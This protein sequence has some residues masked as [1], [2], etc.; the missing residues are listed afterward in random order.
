VRVDSFSS[1]AATTAT[2]QVKKTT[3]DA[4]TSFKKLPHAA[5][6]HTEDTTTLSSSTDSVNSLTNTALQSVSGRQSKVDSLKAAVSSGQYKLDATKIA[7]ALS[8]SDG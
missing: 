1:A 2:E 7:E 4:S 3:G 5:K 6:S 8:S